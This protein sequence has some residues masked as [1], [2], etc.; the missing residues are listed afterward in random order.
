MDIQSVYNIREDEIEIKGKSWDDEKVRSLATKKIL[1]FQK[2][3]D[4]N[5]FYFSRGKR[6]FNMFQGNILTDIQR[7][8]YETVEE[9]IVI[10]P[11]IMKAPI[12]S[13]VGQTIKSRR[14]GQIITEGGNFDEESGSTEEIE[15]VNII[16]KDMEIKTGEKYKIRDAIHDCYVSCYANCLYFDKRNPNEPGEGKYTLKHLPWNSVVFGPIKIQETDGSDIREMMWFEPRTQADLEENFPEMKS[17]IRSH[18]HDNKNKD[19][20]LLSSLLEWEGDYSAEY[21]DQLFDV[22]DNAVSSVN[23]PNGYIPVVQHLFPIKRKEEVWL[24]KWDDTKF[25]VRPPEWSDERWSKW[26]E[27]NQQNYFGPAERVVVTLWVTVFTLTG[28][29]L[30]NKKHWFQENGRLPASFWIADIING[31]FSGPV[32]DMADDCLANCIGEIEYLDDLRKGS[33]SLIAI[34]EGTVTNV[35]DLPTEVSKA[36]GFAFINKDFQGGAGDA[37]Q[38]LKRT[39]NEHWKV[40]AEQRKGAMAEITRLNETMQGATAPRQAA[41]AKDVEITQALIVNAIYIDNVNRCW[42]YHQNLK[43]LLIPY[44]YNEWDVIE[45]KDDE[46]G[47]ELK[48]EVNKPVG[49][50]NEG[51]VTHVE[52][53]LTAHRYRWKLNPVDDSPSAKI[54][55]MQEALTVINAAAGPLLTKD[56]TGKLFARFLMAMDNDFLKKAGKEMVADVQMTSEQQSKVQEQESLREALVEMAK[57]KA[58]LM[59]AEKQGVTLSFKAEDLVN[60]PKM[61]EYYN[62]IQQMFNLAVDQNMSMLQNQNTGALNQQQQMSDPMVAMA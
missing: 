6:F 23:S 35:E 20:Y 32:G 12:R 56:P 37:I 17:Q 43:C 48:T 15:T 57:A 54:R 21:R 25:E 16:L 55:S 27:E 4:A 3:I 51:N 14:S 62:Q 10:E 60:F 58:E 38:E 44:G 45:V 28:L 52:N 24:H 46:S 49:W 29:V 2:M 8:T 22:V 47:D 9:K 30:S 18:L 7:E 53:D 31:R 42:E 33:G 19:N 61:F 5:S 26:I 41:I 34:K 39:P 59:K 13:L 50:D 1:H 40:W 11:P 36:T